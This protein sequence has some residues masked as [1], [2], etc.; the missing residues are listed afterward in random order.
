MG[1]LFSWGSD[2]WLQIE[3]GPFQSAQRLPNDDEDSAF[4]GLSVRLMA[5]K[6]HWGLIRL[7]MVPLCARTLQPTRTHTCARARARTLHYHFSLE[8]HRYSVRENRNK[9]KSKMYSYLHPSQWLPHWSL[10]TNCVSHRRN[11]SKSKSQANKQ[12]SR[13]K[14]LSSAGRT[15]KLLRKV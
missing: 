13:R 6:C 2:D 10:C 3:I 11:I 12:S 8:P 9:K 15:G 7:E 5:H 1:Y 14:P 4:N